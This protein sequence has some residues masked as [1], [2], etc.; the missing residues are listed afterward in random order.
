MLAELMERFVTIYE[1]AALDGHPIVKAN[2]LNIHALPNINKYVKERPKYE[3][4][5]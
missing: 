2:M 5:D 1:P 3:F 4:V